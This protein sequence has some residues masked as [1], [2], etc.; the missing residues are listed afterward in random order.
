MKQG[1]IYTIES[2]AISREAKF[3]DAIKSSSRK[4]NRADRY[5]VILRHPTKNL[6]FVPI[7]LSGFYGDVVRE[8]MTD[9]EIES[10]EELPSDWVEET[11]I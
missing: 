10:I 11:T 5:C 1:L 9:E 3:F 6:W 4:N 8:G 7:S 2:E